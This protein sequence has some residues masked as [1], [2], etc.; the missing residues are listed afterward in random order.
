MLLTV[1]SPAVFATSSSSM[2]VQK[3]IYASIL[4]TPVAAPPTSIDT[5]SGGDLVESHRVSWRL[6][7][8]RGLS[9]GKEHPLLHG[10]A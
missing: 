7:P 2:F 1:E 9:H 5:I 8:L 6:I 4:S 3:T 10:A